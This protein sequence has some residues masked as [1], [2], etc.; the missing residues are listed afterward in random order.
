MGVGEGQGS[1][2]CHSPW[3]CKE[4]EKTDGLNYKSLTEWQYLLFA[5]VSAGW[6]SQ[7]LA[8]SCP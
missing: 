8:N 3:G 5:A 1:L 2:A 4:S 6:S 7:E